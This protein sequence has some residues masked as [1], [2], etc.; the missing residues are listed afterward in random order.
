MA[1]G[2][3]M[4]ASADSDAKLPANGERLEFGVHRLAW[5]DRDCPAWPKNPR[6][7]ADTRYAALLRQAKKDTA[8]ILAVLAKQNERA[9]PE[10]QEIVVNDEQFPSGYTPE[11]AAYEQETR[12]PER[13]PKSKRCTSRNPALGYQ[14]CDM[15]RNHVGVCTAGGYSWYRGRGHIRPRLISRPAWA[16]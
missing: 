11:A 7:K 6:T 15:A 4:H 3:W 13:I 1:Y 2:S 14:S 10:P 9:Q 5:V 8:Y 12:I 16:A